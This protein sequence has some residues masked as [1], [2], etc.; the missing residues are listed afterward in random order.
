M[1]IADLPNLGPKSQQMLVLAGVTS[2][3][4]LRSLGSVASYALVKRS[5]GNPSLNLLWALEGVLTGLPWQVV[6]R[7]HRT[8]LLLALDDYEQQG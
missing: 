5:G 2:V 6:A 1:S 3:E 4:Q 7:D 8:S